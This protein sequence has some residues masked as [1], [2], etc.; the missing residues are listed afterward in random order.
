[1]FSV[2]QRGTFLEELLLHVQPDPHRR[3]SVSTTKTRFAADDLMETSHFHSAGFQQ[4]PRPLSPHPPPVSVC[5]DGPVCSG[6]LRGEVRPDDRGLLQ[7]GRRS[8]AGLSS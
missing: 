8:A 3:S 7:E 6:N 5:A 2:K 1:M 4:R